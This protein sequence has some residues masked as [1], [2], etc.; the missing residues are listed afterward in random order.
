MASCGRARGKPGAGRAKL[1][2][3]RGFPG[4]PALRRHPPEVSLPSGHGHAAFE[5]LNKTAGDGIMWQGDTGSP[6]AGR[7]KHPSSPYRELRLTWHEKILP[8]L[9]LYLWSIAV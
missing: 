7:S 6:G 2:L 8:G 1:R 5:R 3:S 9:L 4:C